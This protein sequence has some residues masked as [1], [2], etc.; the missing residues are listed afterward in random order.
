MGGKKISGSGSKLNCAT[1]VGSGRMISGT[2]RVG[3]QFKARA[4]LYCIVITCI[5]LV[6]ILLNM[7]IILS[8]AVV[9]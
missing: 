6:S 2:G 5:K 9:A 4:D 1:R 3:L 8:G 7:P